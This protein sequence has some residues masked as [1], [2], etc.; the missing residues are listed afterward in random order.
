MTSPRRLAVAL[1]CVTLLNAAGARTA[2]AQLAPLFPSSAQGFCRGAGGACSVVDIYIHPQVI[3]F[4]GIDR[5][6]LSFTSP[7]W[8]LLGAD[9][10]FQSNPVGADPATSGAFW[11]GFIYDSRR[12]IELSGRTGDDTTPFGFRVFLDGY[13]TE[14]ELN[15]GTTASYGAWAPGFDPPTL[16]GPVGASTVPEPASVALLAGGVALLGLGTAHR[17]RRR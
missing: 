15:S 6:Q 9:F 10:S 11:S 2:A 14:A 12:S 16:A 4:V 3:P 13:G 5:V 17:R 7:G 1:G 8:T